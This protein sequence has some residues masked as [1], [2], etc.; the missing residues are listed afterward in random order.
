MKIEKK[1]LQHSGSL[2]ATCYSEKL[3]LL[4]TGGAD[5]IVASW[6][7]KT[8]E[9]TDFSIK[10]KSTVL[11][12]TIVNEKHLVIGLF[13]GDVHII[14]LEQKKEIKFI[15]HHKK[16]V[17]AAKYDAVSN[18][19]ILGSGDGKMSVWNCETFELLL[20]KDL[21][22]SKIRAIEIHQERA[23]IGTSEGVLYTINLK[24]LILLDSQQVN[25]EG[26]NSLCSLP[27]KNAILIGGKGAHLA[28]YSLEK[29]VA[30]LDIAA[31]N[32]AIYKLL[33]INEYLYSCSR[34]KTIKQWDI[35]SLDLVERYSYP[36]H[37]AHTHS[38]NNLIYVKKHNYLVSV[39]D[40]KAICFWKL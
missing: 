5:N 40:D 23:Y 27:T 17:F 15:T 31:H 20:S 7:P 19:L 33:V 29:K 1:I 25:E 11:S 3:D 30:V 21:S 16:G 18:Y 6:D 24:E 22:D 28:V 35:N 12:L 13:N 39:G 2:Y 4:F 34:D 26:I 36:E 37:K 38:V 9:N 8:F 10:T 14:D 32:W